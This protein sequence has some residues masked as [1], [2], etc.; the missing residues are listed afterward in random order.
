MDNLE[1]NEDIKK[2]L[3]QCF[4]ETLEEE[5]RERFLA[6][7][8]ATE[9]GTKVIADDYVPS[10]KTQSLPDE[11]YSLESGHGNSSHPGS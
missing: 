4:L 9:F 2:W 3:F 5:R 1:L 6:Y 7:I 11:H 8:K 10:P